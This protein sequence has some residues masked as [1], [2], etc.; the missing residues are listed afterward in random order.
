MYNRMI[1][2]QYKIF[3]QNFRD[4]L[5]T[6]SEAP[7]TET[8]KAHF[9]LVNMFGPKTLILWKESGRITTRQGHNTKGLI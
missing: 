9:K 3:G 5:A 4:F 1:K 7:A 6:C 2:Q 8:D